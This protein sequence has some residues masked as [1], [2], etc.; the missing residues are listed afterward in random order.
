MSRKTPIRAVVLSAGVGLVAGGLVIALV[1][2]LAAALGSWT[3]GLLAAGI[4]IAVVGLVAAV[5]GALGFAIFG[6]AK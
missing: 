4:A 6:S 1:G 5:V 3:S 2:H